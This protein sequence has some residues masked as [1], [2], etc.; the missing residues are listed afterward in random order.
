MSLTGEFNSAL[1]KLF[2]RRTAW[3][4]EAI[5]SN[6]PG[7]RRKY[8]SKRVKKS[9]NNICCV[10]RR[11]LVREHAND[12]LADDVH[13]TR[14]WHPKKGK[15]HGRAAKQKSFRAWYRKK[16]A[17][18][19][20]VY[21]FWNKNRCLYVGRTIRGA[22]RPDDHF[23]KHWFGSVTQIDILAIR[24]PSLVPKVECIA[25]DKY[26]PTY[27]R[28]KAA[29]KHYAKKCPVCSTERDVKD[30]LKTIFRVK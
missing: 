11:I 1:R 15:G 16:I 2:E 29:D 8:N 17:Y 22:G 20:C 28:V 25:M 4:Q 9:I 27:C 18:R 12:V 24:Q 14:R 21:L 3:L 10:A 23:E 13:E 26:E 30:E 7:P 19:N 5:G 6:G